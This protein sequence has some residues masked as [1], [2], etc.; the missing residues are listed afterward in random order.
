VVAREELITIASRLAQASES[1][2]DGT[3]LDGECSRTRA[4][5]RWF[6][7]LRA[8]SAGR[9]SRA[10]PR[11][12]PLLSSRTICSSWTD[13]ICGSAARRA[14][15]ALVQ[16]C[17]RGGRLLLSEEVPRDLEDLGA[18]LRGA[19][20][21]SRRLMFKRRDSPYRSGGRAATGGSGRSIVQHRRVLVYAQP[22]TA[23]APTCSPT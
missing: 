9:S 1:L 12:C 11:R 21:R 17:G 3:V 5:R 23:A 8:A 2:P 20:A 19:R 7:V 18:A 14:P 13:A 22:A 4:E 6:S 10:D 15:R 16:L